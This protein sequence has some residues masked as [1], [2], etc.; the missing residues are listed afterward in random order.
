MCVNSRPFGRIAESSARPIVVSRIPVFVG[1]MNRNADL[2]PRLQLGGTGFER[3]TCFVEV[4]QQHALTLRIDALTG[5][6]IQAKYDILRR[7]DDRIAVCRRQ[8]VVGR[9]HQCAGFELC[10]DRERHVY[11]HLVTVEVGVECRT[12][13]RMQLDS[14]AFD[15]DRLERLD[16]ETVQGRCTVQHD[17][18]L[19]DDLLE[20]IPDLRSLALDEALGCLDGRR[21]A[22]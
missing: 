22:A 18:V 6:V 16:A 20:N 4:G 9:H 17:R 1:L 10:F 15:E 14:L 11:G 8:D 12:N 21:L 19:A 2:H 7:H 3:P 13:E 5:Q